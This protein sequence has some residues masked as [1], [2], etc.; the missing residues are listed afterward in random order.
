MIN[1]DSTCF[2]TGHRILSNS[3]IEYLKKEIKIIASY[4]IEQHNVTDFITG[5]AIGFD[6]IAAYTILELKK[7]YPQ[8]KLHLYLP[9][10]DQA[11]NWRKSDINA[12]NDILKQA[13]S[14][15]YIFN[16]TYMS[17][18]MQMRNRA[19]VTDSKYC[20]AY[21][22]RPNS[23]SASTIAYAKEKGHYISMIN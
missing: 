21:C 12:W 23:G 17:G 1:P 18:C 20:I 15:K 6:T 19:M 16:H 14:H 2:F 7:S 10:T 5:G 4:F 3:Q 8:I 9:C 11:K 13:D 22:T